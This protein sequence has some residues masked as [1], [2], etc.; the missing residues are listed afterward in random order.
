MQ[1]QAESHSVTSSF[2][3]HAVQPLLLPVAQAPR[4]AVAQVTSS[5]VNN[6][7]L[8]VHRWFRYSAGFSANWVRRLIEEQL[9]RGK[10]RLL[11]PFAGSGTTLIEAERAGVEAVGIDAHP[12]VYRVAQ[13][14]L[15]W[16]SDADEYVEKIRALK[17]LSDELRPEIE[18]YPRLIHACFSPESLM[19]LDT[20]RQALDAVKDD[21][22]AFKLTWL[23]VVGI[24]R[25]VA[26]A[27]TAQWQYVLPKKQKRSPLDPAKAL[28]EF[29]DMVYA[30][31][32]FGKSV[33]GPRATLV[34]GDARSCAELPEN[35]FNLVVTSPPYPNNYDYADAT[36][37]EMSFMREINGWSELH[38]AVRRHLVHSCSQHANEKAV[39]LDSVL[40]LPQLSPIRDELTR[41][42][43]ELGTIRESKGGR[44]AYHLMVAGYFRDLAL[45]WIALRRVCASPCRVCFV[46]GDSAPYGIYVPVMKWLGELAKAAGF[47]E[48]SFQKIR[49]RNI[50]W[51]NRK[52]RVPLQEGHLWVKG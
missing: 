28:E 17:L 49:D 4:Q 52:H 8:P 1:S 32:Q 37:L 22:P 50:K 26:T 39:D 21:S 3:S 38:A 44:K 25:K 19:K 15:A 36:R 35:F 6:M 5:F 45:V 43:Y 18:T 2:G 47:S 31:L 41:V 11:D 13:A 10:V 16:R 34:A 30:D 24:L 12:F 20:F 48:V 23:T 9:A 51:K 33:L 40:S 42:C 14:K 29:V 27:G 46:I 7:S